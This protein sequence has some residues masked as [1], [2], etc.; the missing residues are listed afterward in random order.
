MSTKTDLAKEIIGKKM[1]FYSKI[2]KTF[3]KETEI[4]EI[5]IETA[6][7]SAFLEKPL[8]RYFTLE[9]D[10]IKD[11]FADMEKDAEA[12]AFVLS[13]FLKGKERVLAAG[14]G[15]S[16]LTADSLGPLFASHLFCGSFFG[17]SLFSVTLGV[18]GRTAVPPFLLLKAAVKELKPDIIIAADALAA[19]GFSEICK[20]VQITDAGI[21]PGSGIGAKTAAFSKKTLG[22]PVI[23]M[24]TPTVIRYP[25]EDFAFVFPKDGDIFIDR[26]AKLLALGL[27]T[28]VFPEFGTETIARV[29][30]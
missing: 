3:Y 6:E 23:A 2:N 27:S 28:A 25:G 1:P 26:A 15:N 9:A 20:T 7:D 24:G 8:G 17:K 22:V 11:P 5:C 4:T 19:E 18:E 13:P 12:L 30:L 10:S 14:V 16:F 21:V 29:M